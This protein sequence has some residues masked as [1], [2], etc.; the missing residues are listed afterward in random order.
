MVVTVPS[1][2]A[3]NTF[4][5]S[6][7]PSFSFNARTSVPMSAGLTCAVNLPVDFSKQ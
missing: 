3:S 1:F 7:E 4:W 2:A 6:G 5:P